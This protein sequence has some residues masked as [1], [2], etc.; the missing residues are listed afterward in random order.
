MRATV[1]CSWSGQT[2]PWKCLSSSVI[3]RPCGHQ[4]RCLSSH[5]L[6]AK[7][8][9]FWHVPVVWQ[10]WHLTIHVIWKY[11]ACSFVSLNETG[12][13]ISSPSRIFKTAPPLDYAKVLLHFPPKFHS[14]PLNFSWALL[15]ILLVF[16]WSCLSVTIKML[17]SFCFYSHFSKRG[18]NN[19]ISYRTSPNLPISPSPTSLSL[20][21]RIID[22]LFSI[23]IVLNTFCFP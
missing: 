23:H 20:P 2:F 14:C 15:I 5:P 16:I 12:S 4:I 11:V 3:G 1:R 7:C 10:I 18:S 9:V 17:F 6:T 19:H 13:P 8:F 21:R 22:A